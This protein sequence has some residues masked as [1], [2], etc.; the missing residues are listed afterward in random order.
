[1]ACDWLTAENLF[2]GM[3]GLIGTLLGGYI[4]YW[5]QDRTENRKR[6]DEQIKTLNK[7]HVLLDKSYW[8]NKGL[9][10]DLL[11][12]AKD[13]PYRHIDLAS[14]HTMLPVLN[15]G[16]PAADLFFLNRQKKGANLIAQIT[17][18]VEGYQSFLD[19]FTKRNA[20]F[21]VG[22]NQEISA[23]KKQNG[24]GAVL[25]KD[26][27]ALLSNHVWTQ[28]KEL[29]E[30]LYADTEY[31]LENYKGVRDNLESISKALFPEEKFVELVGKNFRVA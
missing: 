16:D 5:V 10:E 24:G 4:T 3:F 1:M 26:L 15:V 17:S 6:A 8:I 29:T 20:L 2:T 31:L 27:E 7:Y 21:E 25:A 22:Y 28:L 13:D 19:V 12:P 23:I 11:S 9:D 30:A 14:I 18:Y